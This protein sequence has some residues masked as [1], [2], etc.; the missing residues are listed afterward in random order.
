MYFLNIQLGTNNTWDTIHTYKVKNT[1]LKKKLHKNSVLKGIVKASQIHTI[2][3]KFKTILNQKRYVVKE[4]KG[5]F[6]C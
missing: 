3:L 1:N 6:Y 5:G 2:K 4:R